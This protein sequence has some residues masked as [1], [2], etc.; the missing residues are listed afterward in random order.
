MF[1]GTFS[2]LLTTLSCTSYTR[3][4]HC[5]ATTEEIQTIKLNRALANLKLQRYDE[6]LADATD[7]LK[8]CK[9]SEKGIYRAARSLYELQRF[10]E[11]RESL[12]LLLD[13]YPNNTEAKDQL[14]RTEKRLSE[15][16]KGE[17]DFKVMYK[18][19]EETPPYLDNATY[20]GPVI[21]K[22]SKGCG[23]GLFTT[24]AVVAGEL[25]LCE[26]AFSY[27]F[28]SEEESAGSSKTSML[29]NTQTKRVT[30]GTQAGLIA[31]TA[32]KMLRNPSLAPSFTALHHG[33]YKPVK[34]TEVDSQPVVDT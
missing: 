7:L 22:I 6:A 3:A 11:C 29:I 30:M 5:P 23:R 13:K 12:T 19:A 4:L 33:D 14:L 18:A 20:S 9:V 21:I 2:C 24:R 10:Q 15:Q 26:K 34:E 27:C 16:E 32:Q 31:A 28:A 25:L 1:P 17:Y 8:E